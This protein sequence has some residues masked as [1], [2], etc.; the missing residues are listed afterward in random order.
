MTLAHEYSDESR[1]EGSIKNRINDRIDCR[2]DV[3]QPEAYHDDVIRDV[4]SGASREKYVQDE[5]GRPAE[6]EGEKHK[7][8]NFG[9][10]LLRRHGIHGEVFPFSLSGQQPVMKKLKFSA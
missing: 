1:S 8:Q 5:E 4:A 3:A 10:L 2:T 6:D 7:S 9:R